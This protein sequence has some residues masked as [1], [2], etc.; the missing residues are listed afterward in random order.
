MELTELEL[1]VSVKK[2]EEDLP[3]WIQTVR[4]TKFDL[5]VGAL[6][7]LNTAIMCYEIEYKGIGD[8]WTLQGLDAVRD[9]QT[10][11]V[12]YYVEHVF[13]GFFFTELMVR[14]AA[15][16]FAYL[17]QLMNVGD[18]I[19]VVISCTDSWLLTPLG[20]EGMSNVAFLRVMRLVRLTK[21]LRVVRVLKAFK[22][23]RVIVCAVAN[24]VGALAWSMTL[25]FVLELVGAIFVAQLL[26]PYV[27][28]ETITL[29][30]RE[31]IWR[32]FGTCGNA[33]F[34]VFEVTMAPGGFLRFRRLSEEISPMFALFFMLYTCV[35]TFAV[36][37][38]ITALFLKATLSA[39]DTEEAQAATALAKE[40]EL[41]ATRLKNRVGQEDSSCLTVE[42]FNDLMAIPQMQEWI[43]ELGMHSS[44]AQRLYSALDSGNGQ[45]EFTDIFGALSAMRQPPRSS[46]IVLMLYENRRILER[47]SNMDEMMLEW[48][49]LPP[50]SRQQVAVAHMRRSGSR[51]V[52]GSTDEGHLLGRGQSSTLNPSINFI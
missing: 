40:R 1:N 29:E 28:D 19:I 38:V 25:L 21:A 33:F 5:A 51:T 52:P 4:S 43:S 44:E 41:L 18:A 37:R 15:D 36:V 47:V 3:P 10:D 35:V 48:S 6:I 39:S 26:Q 24:S 20:S 45:V 31:F 16:G 42:E 17:K 27:V 13:T 30:L 50:G 22:S 49:S 11:D 34:S 8:R 14:L 2:P 23:L 7:V 9:T 46:D 12:F 32:N